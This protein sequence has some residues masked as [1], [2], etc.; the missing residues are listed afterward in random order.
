MK[1]EIIRRDS[2]DDL[3]LAVNAYIT[4]QEWEPLG[5]VAVAMYNDNEPLWCQAM[6]KRQAAELTPQ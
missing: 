2:L 3:I 6:V 1:Y 5:G 4:Q